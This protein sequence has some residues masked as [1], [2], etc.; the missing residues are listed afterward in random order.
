MPQQSIGGR[1]VDYMKRG[2]E[3]D[4]SKKPLERTPQQQAQD[5]S[6]AEKAMGPRFQVH[7]ASQPSVIKSVGAVSKEETAKKRGSVVNIGKVN[8]ASVVQ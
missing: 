8:H 6:A 1:I 4:T 2:W 5:R 3:R 7:D